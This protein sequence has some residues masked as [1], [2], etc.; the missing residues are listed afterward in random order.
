MDT[1]NFVGESSEEEKEEDDLK[2]K[3]SFDIKDTIKVGQLHYVDPTLLDQVEMSIE[4]I[5]EKDHMF[6]S[7]STIDTNVVKQPI[8]NTDLTCVNFEPTEPE[9]EPMRIEPS[10][11]R[12]TEKSFTESGSD[13]TSSPSIISQQAQHTVELG[14][15]D[16]EELEKEEEDR[17]IEEVKIEKGTFVVVDARTWPGI[18]KLGGAGRVTRVYEEKDQNGNMIRFYDVRYVMGGFERRI[19]E[20]YVHLSDL[21]K[22]NQGGRVRKERVFYH[23]KYTSSMSKL[24]S[25]RSKG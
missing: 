14:E 24:G 23:G 4:D 18:N 21:L 12:N 20:E 22:N 17:D 11:V 10:T 9:E 8:P 2:K 25:Y 3:I 5:T 6:N 1:E 15:E 16:E 13:V 7:D 19:E